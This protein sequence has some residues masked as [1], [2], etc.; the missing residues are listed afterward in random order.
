MEPIITVTDHG[1][2][3]V[4]GDVTVRSVDGAILRTGGPA[5]LCR[6]GGS[7]NKPFCDATHG[8]KGFDGTETA[9]RGP[10]GD[11]H[12]TYAAGP[13]TVYDDRTICAHFGQCTTRLPGV[14]RADREPFIDPDAAA[15][16]E[17][18]DVIA[19]CPSG[20]LS[21]AAGEDRR[22]FERDRE[23]AI[24]PISDGP[25]RVTGGVQVV[26]E[27]GGRYEPRARQTL[28][29]CGQSRNKPF[30]DGSHWYAGFRDPQPAAERVAPPTPYEWVGGMPALL[31]LTQRFY[32]QLLVEPDTILEPIFRHMDPAHPEHVAA[33]LA[34]TLGGPTVYTSEHGGYERM[35]SRHRGLALTKQQRERW[36]VRMLR[37]ADDVDLPTDPDFRSTLA[38]YLEWGTQIAV[39]NSAPGVEPMAHA[40]VPRW[41]WGLTPP[42]VPQPWDDA[43]AA[44]RGRGRYAAEQAAARTRTE[45]TP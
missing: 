17:I 40:P 39:L 11:R 6:C 25:Y 23:A 30:C 4:D 42:Y 45:V 26:S 32:T 36:I 5:Y 41:G 10:T 35:V 27:T 14:F 24:T 3:R 9:D 7:R 43:D 18:A 37:A 28:C 31:R 20:A 22:S 15:P 1:P 33:W 21:Y 13:V 16:A 2:Y 12:D 44:E 38:A 34:E 8:L 29:R 19:N